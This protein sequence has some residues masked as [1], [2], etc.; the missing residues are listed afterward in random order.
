MKLV[1]CIVRS[2]KVEETT[3]ALKQLDV[4][5][6]TVTQVAGHGQRPNPTVVFRG[7][8]GEPRYLPHMMID[9]VVA[10]CVVEDVV[11]TVIETARTGQ[12]GDGR[13]FVIPVEQA[14]S[15]RTRIGGPD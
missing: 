5:G 13:V 8:R 12:V 15:V 9:V 6:F 10:D 2:C 1:K 7:N 14:Y 11:K 3:D 4:S